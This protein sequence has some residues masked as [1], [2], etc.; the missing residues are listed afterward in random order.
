MS[1]KAGRVFFLP[2]GEQLMAGLTATAR[3]QVSSEWFG[4]V[5]LPLQHFVLAQSDAL[6]R[7]TF[8]VDSRELAGKTHVII[9]FWHRSY[10]RSC[11]DGRSGCRLYGYALAPPTQRAEVCKNVKIEGYDSSSGRY[12]VCRQGLQMIVPFR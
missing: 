12:D 10:L 8:E 6:K 11:S 1:E 2:V 7:F 9:G 3:Q 5:D 4:D